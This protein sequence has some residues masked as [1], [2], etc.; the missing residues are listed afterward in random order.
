LVVG[1]YG[2]VG[3][4]FIWAGWWLVHAHVLLVSHGTSLDEEKSY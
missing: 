1:L 3:G 2:L 4:W